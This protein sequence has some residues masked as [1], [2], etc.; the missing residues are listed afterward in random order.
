[1]VTLE[2]AYA[3]RTQQRRV[4]RVL[5]AFGDR[6]EAETLSKAK[7]VAQETPVLPIT[8]KILHNGTIELDNIE[9]QNL[10]MA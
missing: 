3:L 2:I 9:R 1:M 8:S 5:D 4:L 10:K 7:E 6:A